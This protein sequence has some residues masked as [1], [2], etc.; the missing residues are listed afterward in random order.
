MRSGQRHE[1]AN[2]EDDTR[3]DHDVPSD[4]EEGAHAPGRWRW[5]A[6]K[7][8]QCAEEALEDI[9]DDVE[10]EPGDGVRVDCGR[11]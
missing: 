1:D 10:V 4:D 11:Q 7:K 5:R 6:M 9:D 3:G 2:D 8:T